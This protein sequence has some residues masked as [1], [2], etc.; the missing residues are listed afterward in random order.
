MVV[1]AINLAFFLAEKALASRVE[2][3]GVAYAFAVFREGQWWRLVSAGFL[4]A[5]WLHILMNSWSLF[6]LVTEVEQF[7]GTSRM[8]VAYVVSTITGF[9]LACLMGPNPILGAS[10]AAFGLMGI[11]LAMGIGQR[12]DPLTQAVR[13]HYGQWL[14]IGVV[15]SLQGGISLSGHRGGL[16]GG[17]IVGVLSGR[18]GHPGSRREVF[19]KVMA[20]CAIALVVLCWYDDF[21][22]ISQVLKHS[23][24]TM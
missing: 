24:A 17:F 16:I 2:D 5:N 13:K 7:Y 22:F 11:M 10:C 15:M 19:W 3:P 23:G 12:A 8:V 9:T 21:A 14:V 4:H 18:P 6:I 20:Y 1:L